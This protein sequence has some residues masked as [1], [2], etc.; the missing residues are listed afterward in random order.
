MGQ[1]LAAEGP[2]SAAAGRYETARLPESRALV[3]LVKKVFPHQYNHI[4]WRFKISM[5]KF[6]AQLL[7]NKIS[8]G[9]IDPPG[10]KLSQDEK[11]GYQELEKRIFKTD[12]TLYAILSLILI[13]LT[14]LA[15]RLF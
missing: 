3:R 7:L 13:A 8:G 4:P 9:W 11:L 5:A 15:I 1:E 2:V 12:L 10:F 14:Y 6:F